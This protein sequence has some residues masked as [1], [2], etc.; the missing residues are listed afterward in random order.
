VRIGNVLL[1]PT[2][3]KLAETIRGFESEPVK[4]SAAAC[5]WKQWK[6]SKRGF[7]PIKQVNEEIG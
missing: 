7:I 2:S 6:R 4:G 1:M 3:K 5:R